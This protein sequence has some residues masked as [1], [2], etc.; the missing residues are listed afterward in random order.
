MWLLCCWAESNGVLGSCAQ[1]T[2]VGV[3]LL[4]PVT[5]HEG[6]SLSR[7]VPELHLDLESL[8]YSCPKKLDLNGAVWWVSIREKWESCQPPAP[9]NVYRHAF[10]DVRIEPLHMP[11]RYSYVCAHSSNAHHTLLQ[12]NGC[13]K[14]IF[15]K[16]YM[17]AYLSGGKIYKNFSPLALSD[18]SLLL[19]GRTE[20]SGSAAPSCSI[21]PISLRN[22]SAAA[23]LCTSVHKWNAAHAAFGQ[24]CPPPKSVCSL[25]AA[26]WINKVQFG[27][28]LS[29]YIISRQCLLSALL[30]LK[31]WTVSLC[32]LIQCCI[33]L[34]G[35]PQLVQLHL[36]NG[37]GFP[38]DSV[39]ACSKMS[40]PGARW[41]LSC[42][43]PLRVKRRALRRH[44]LP[45]IVSGT[46]QVRVPRTVNRFDR[47]LEGS[48]EVAWTIGQPP[49]EKGDGD[50][51]LHLNCWQTCFLP[52]FCS[53]ISCG[54][55]PC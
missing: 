35:G 28:S 23:S 3:C 25:I 1:P 36:A 8:K 43:F 10:I 6:Q 34:P 50:N 29:L 54:N 49:F 33:N 16:C 52:Y 12:E 20:L 41:R 30:Q 55:A 46:L 18:V 40:I 9:A 4:M 22:V 19:P 11:I 38:W 51:C 27:T 2:R 21:S 26:A 7:V 44:G 24:W 45:F 14:E 42:F 37:F 5:N 53:C 17:C 13:Y 47:L 15:P 32:P 31:N 39:V 48:G